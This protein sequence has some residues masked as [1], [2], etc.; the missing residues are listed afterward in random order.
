MAL[1]HALEEKPRTVS[2][3]NV[4]T[5]K[6]S[7]MEFTRQHLAV[8]IR[9]MSYSAQTAAILP[10]M[11]H[12]A[13]VNDNFAPLARQ[14]KLQA[15]SLGSSLATGMQHAVLC[16]EDAPFVSGAEYPGDASTYL[17]EG[18]VDSLEASC[19]DW[20][21]G[22]I[23]GDFKDPVVSETPTLILSGE[24]D[25]ITPPEYGESLM[26]NFTQAKHIVNPAQGHMQA[27][28]GCMPVVLAKFIETANAYE[29]N[30]DCLE[31]L[32]ALPFFIDANGPLP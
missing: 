8:T 21:P 19:A 20:P 13:I 3:E 16:T 23:D 1:L 6:M 11:L 12:E 10:S 9:L 14:S 29:L 32:R 15:K 18:V 4:V 28:F 2:F 22:I 17:G 7:T 27:P 24:A 26:S 5:G 31:R 25:P 30:T